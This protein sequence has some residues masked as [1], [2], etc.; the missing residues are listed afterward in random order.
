MTL[1]VLSYNKE[2][3]I[4]ESVSKFAKEKSRVVKGAKE[5]TWNNKYMK[6]IEKPV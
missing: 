1:Q 3:N 4:T 5:A 6:I 2:S